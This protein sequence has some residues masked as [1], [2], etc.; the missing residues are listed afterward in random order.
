MSLQNVTI[1]VTGGRQFDDKDRLERALDMTVTHIRNKYGLNCNICLTS[2]GA[3]GADELAENW[4]KDRGDIDITVMK[5][6]WDC[7]GKAAGHIR[8]ADMLEHSI[9]TSVEVFCVAFP[10]G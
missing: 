6:N 1:Q 8:N 5:P 7:Y 9:R 4:A 2:G 3:N 10:A